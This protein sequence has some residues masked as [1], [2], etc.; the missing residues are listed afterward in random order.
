ML[1]LRVRIIE[2]TTKYLL[3]HKHMCEVFVYHYMFVCISIV[4]LPAIHAVLEV[5]A[6]TR[7]WLYYCPEACR[8][9]T[10]LCL[11]CCRTG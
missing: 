9:D 3:M 1:E 4:E 7:L 10:T 11:V 5:G 8:T 2:R 6:C